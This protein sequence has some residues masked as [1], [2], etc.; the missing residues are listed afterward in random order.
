VSSAHA[1][2]GVPM[3][4]LAALLETLCAPSAPWHAPCCRQVA[5]DERPGKG[6]RTD[7]PCL[8]AGSVATGLQRALFTLWLV[9]DAE[10]GGCR[11][12]GSW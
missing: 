11:A 10:C 9:C 7:L 4:L 1:H 5:W 6:T 2:A 8:A 12:G 3:L